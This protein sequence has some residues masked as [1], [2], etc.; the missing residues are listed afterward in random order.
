MDDITPETITDDPEQQEA[1]REFFE[2]YTDEE[3]V[4]FVNGLMEKMA[5]IV[6]EDRHGQNMMGSTGLLFFHPDGLQMGVAENVEQPLRGVFLAEFFTGFINASADD[7]DTL[8]ETAYHL[9]NRGSR[10]RLHVFACALLDFIGEEQLSPG[11]FEEY[12]EDLEADGDDY[13]SF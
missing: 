9:A 5:S 13:V 12:Y 1:L 2:E 6:A 3:R 7:S 11:E 10:V 4:E 8:I